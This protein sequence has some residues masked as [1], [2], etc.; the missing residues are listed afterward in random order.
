MNAEEL[1]V[2]AAKLLYNDY[3]KYNNGKI[4]KEG[5]QLKPETKEEKQKEKGCC[6]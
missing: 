4:K 6:K 1:F 2:E 5:E 3:K